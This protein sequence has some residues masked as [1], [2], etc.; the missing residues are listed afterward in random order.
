VVG[1]PKQ[2]VLEIDEL[3]R[4]VDRYDLPAAVA[5]QLL[6]E[7]KTLEQERA[8]GRPLPFAHHVGILTEALARIRQA[9][10]RAPVF[11]RQVDMF[12]P[13]SNERT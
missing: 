4:N 9:L 10:K 1:N 6:A 5:K 8:V 13:P 2:A 7:R 12:R 3:G 11:R